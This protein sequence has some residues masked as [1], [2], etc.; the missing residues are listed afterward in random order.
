[1]SEETVAPDPTAGAVD[2]LTERPRPGVALVT[3]NRP[4]KLNALTSD[5]LGRVYE[6]LEHLGRDPSCRV[7]VVTGS[8]R[9]FCAGDDL[10]DWHPPAWIPADLGP[11]HTNMYQQ[12]FVAQLVPR[13][14][15]LPQPVIA[16]VN[17][18][19][20]GAGYALALGADLRVASTSALFVDAFVKIGASGA[21]M[22]LSWLLQRIVGATRAAELVLTGRPVDGAEAAAIGLVLATVP[23]AELLDAALRLADQIV[24]NTPL[25][26]WMGKATLWS[27]LE[28]PSLEA[29]IDLEA[30]TQI[31]TLA[32]EDAK[33]QLLAFKERRPAH[34]ENR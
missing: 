5:M 12:K 33:E 2:V 8:G 31:L 30:R 18:P 27:N 11:V 10:L 32:T 19:A 22:G 13:M 15:S 21:E 16:A 24:V 14:R 34:Y 6:T 26:T 20:A 4:E 3:L 7:I 28:I 25:G 9:G 1:M 23:D 17:G 29:A